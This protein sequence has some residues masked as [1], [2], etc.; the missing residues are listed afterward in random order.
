ML[1][2]FAA[3]VGHF[4][5]LWIQRFLGILGYCSEQC[6]I[7]HIHCRAIGTMLQLRKVNKRRYGDIFYPALQR[8]V[9]NIITNKR[10]WEANVPQ[11]LLPV[12]RLV[13]TLQST[14][15]IATAS[16]SV[17][18][19]V[20]AKSSHTWFNVSQFVHLEYIY[21]QFKYSSKYCKSKLYHIVVIRLCNLPG[22]KK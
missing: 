12:H 17:S 21:G 10:R 14:L 15:A 19:R 6:C 1:H 16:S 4:Y 9:K 7:N 2:D 8:I 11:W 13:S 22:C 3:V 5:S 20:L 18:L